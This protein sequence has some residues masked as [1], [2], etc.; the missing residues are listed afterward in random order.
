MINLSSLDDAT[1][2]VAPFEHVIVD[3]LF[4][5]SDAS[6]L[7]ETYP[8][9]HFKSVC[10]ADTEKG[11]AYDVRELIGMGARAPSHEAALSP[12]WRELAW[13]LLHPSYR[14]SLSLLTERDLHQVPIEVNVFH[15]AAGAW[16]G[17]HVDLSD[18]IVTHVLYFN[19][20]WNAQD[21][22]CLK[23]LRSRESHDTHQRVPPIVGASAVLVR[24]N[25]SWHAVES[26][27]SG[28][29][30]S[31]R[32]MTVTFYKPGSVST[33]WPPLSSRG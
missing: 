23:I 14:A 4:R 15:Y 21:G 3:N 11:Y 31:R 26:V 13:D 12:A 5:P 2:S 1:L 19:E 16:L 30:Q 8:R 25:R 7:A 32:S 28:V 10:G 20:Q 18:K 22:G 29:Q 24:S 6:A 9:E 33:M 27:T 17:P